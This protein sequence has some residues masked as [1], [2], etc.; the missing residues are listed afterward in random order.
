MAMERTVRRLAAVLAADVVGYS[1]KIEADESSTLASL[2]DVQATTIDPLLA[3]HSGRIV[4][5]MGDGFIAEF[6]SVVDAVTFAVAMQK[7]VTERQQGTASEKRLVYRIGINLGD[8]VVEGD[9]LLGDGVNV[10]ARLEQIC[11][12]GG[13]LISGTAYDHL[14]GKLGL[15]LD[16]TGEQRVKNINRSVRTYAVRLDGSAPGWRRALPRYGK[17]VR[18]VIA[19]ALAALMVV[20]G[21]WWYAHRAALSSVPSI[22][23]MPFE[24]AGGDPATDRLARGIAN[25]I[26]IDFSRLRN[27][28]VIGSSTTE[29]YG[30]KGADVRRI[31]RDLKVRYVL[32]GAIQREGDQ[33][34]VSAQLQ[35]G[36]TGASL[37]SNR[38]DRPSGDIFA[39][40]NE[41]SDGVISTLGGRGLLTSL[42][43]TAARRKGPS[44]LEAY[45][46]FALGMAD[47]YKGGEEGF[48]KSIKLF[49]AAIDKDPQFGFAYVKKGWAILNHALSANG[50]VDEAGS[51][52]ERL[53]R[54]AIEIDPYGAEGHV[55]LGDKLVWWGDFAQGAVEV[56][57]ALEL[58]PSSADI[59]ALS[60][61]A[62]PQLGRP[63]Q[64]AAQCDKAYRLN[65]APPPFYP[66]FCYQN[67]FFTKRY[68]ESAEATKRHDAWLGAHVLDFLVFRAAAQIEAGA[69]DDAAA[70]IAEWKRKY[71][72]VPVE[73]YMTDYTAYS[74]QQEADQLVASLHKAGAPMCVPNEKLAD[75]P[76]LQHLKI[77]DEERAKQAVR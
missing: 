23:V 33:L 64:G 57:R 68:R 74:R 6:G 61:G 73:E 67:Y 16:F 46:L 26:S 76:K 8:V 52:F 10:A 51:E 60:A 42:A 71:P 18:P 72:Q 41:V 21:S 15:P 7:S 77:C 58:N 45:D 34:R 20:G 44:D 30:S 31:A 12:P 66:A 37:W 13:I 48:A 3:E 59:M 65:S 49:D 63:E 56:E 27:L 4:K 53:S 2:K 43:A 70:T 38:W 69:A 32:T 62:M 19:A 14:Q 17:R 50:D 36:E 29:A 9:D 55:S 25:D 75:F 5:T 28:D 24:V 40:Q 35:D 11:K 1:G 22:A 39:V 54:K 47:F